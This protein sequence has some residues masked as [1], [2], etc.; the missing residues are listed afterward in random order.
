MTDIAGKIVLI[1]GGAMGIG[2]ELAR[3]CVKE[4]ARLVLVDI[5]RS[6]LEKTA[7]ELRTAGGQVTTY[8][9]DISKREAV[10]DTVAKIKK[11][12]GAPDIL[13]NNAGVLYGGDFLAMPEDLL[14]K[15]M[16]IN[17]MAHMWT[18][19]AF[20]PGMIARGTGHVVNIASAAG[21]FG[22]P[23]LA[24]YC[25]SKHAVIGLTDAV[26]LEMKKQRHRGIRFTTVCPS[27]VNTTLVTGVSAPRFT[28]MLSPQA[29]AEK[30]VE[31][32]KRDKVTV[33]APSS[34]NLVPILK[35]LLPSRAFDWV[36]GFL[37]V[38]RSMDAWTGKG[39]KEGS[40]LQS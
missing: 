38:H 26:R 31:A 13:I 39:G 25:A 19:R 18:M 16:D 2:R 21:L 23:E 1:T 29:I 34:V 36:T 35:A 22:V 5:V 28:P 24:A 33:I 20:L 3:L 37:R 8:V 15:T 4:G 9:C 30:I 32:V 7:Q 14:R 11:D 10:D 17:I 12:P 40:V 27:F 6:D